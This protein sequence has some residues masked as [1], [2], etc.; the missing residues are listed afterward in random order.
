[1]SA[2][3]VLISTGLLFVGVTTMQRAELNRLRT[4]L[5]GYELRFPRHLEAAAVERLLAGVTGLLPPWW[6]RWID[7]PFVVCEISADASG[8][9]HRLLVPRAY[10]HTIENALQAHMPNVRYERVDIERPADAIGA[11]YRLSTG[12]RPLATDAAALSIGLLSS[13]QPLG[14]GEAVAVQWVLAPAAPVA[15][16]RVASA[17]ERPHAFGAQ[18][19]TVATSE[20]ATA[21][22]Q[23]QARPLLLGVSRIA[24]TARSRE[25]ARGLLRQVEATWHATRAPGVQL[26]RRLLLSEARVAKRIE[27]VAVP[28]K[29]WPAIYNVEELAGLLGWPIDVEQLPGLVLGGCREL[30]PSPLIPSTGTVIGQATFPGAGR[31]L[32]LDVEARLRHVHVCAPTGTGKSTLLLNMIVG[33][34]ERGRGVVVIDP[35]GD[36]VRDVLARVPKAR[37]DDVIVLDPAD[38]DRPVGLNP[39]RVHDAGQHE[40]VV[41]NLVGLFKSLYR[42][43]WGPRTDDILRAALLTLAGSGKATLCE[44]P[45]LLTDP[46]YRR[47]LV[48]QLDDPVGLE[49]FW[50]WYEGLSD[51]ERLSVVGP[52]LNKVRAFSMR[53]RVRA[54]IGQAEPVLS[55]PRVIN[56]GQVLLVSLASGLLGDEAAALLGALVFAELWHATT[57][58]AGQD[59]ATRQPVMAYLDEFQHFL[60]LPTPIASVLAEARGFGL[61]LTLAH[62]HLGQL[63]DGVRDEVLANARSRVVFQLPAHDARLFARELGSDLT[64]DDLHGLGAFEVVTQLFAAGRTQPAA[65][66]RTMAA[67]EPCS[68]PGEIQ[69]GSRE[70]YG[71]ERAEVERSIRGRQHHT[72]PDAPVRRRRRPPESE[73]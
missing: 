66:A 10:A 48:G 45:L 73:R 39:L 3:V 22:R 38:D 6:R 13:M 33:D 35:K 58:R 65:T 17:N 42:S 71:L 57:A 11:E 60:H 28:G 18:R 12:Q 50:G 69:R 63:T 32:A 68:D 54:I 5:V 16:A 51:A 56:E 4:S 25:R 8:I 61:G 67:P 64:P 21:L 49:S 40:L 72:A 62:Q 44:V 9:T 30:A 52:V 19:G 43:S 70:G 46:A 41:E 2:S 47:R 24:V 14:E 1:M 59:V 37:R 20:E 34:L 26:R 27:R 29:V 53:P 15:P 23:K 36:L 7:T 31:S 55:L